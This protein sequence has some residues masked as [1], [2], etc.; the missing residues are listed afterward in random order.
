MSE[1]LLDDL[2]CRGNFVKPVSGACFGSPP[3]VYI[4]DHDTAP[5]EG[6]VVTQDHTNVVI[7]A[8][9]LKDGGRAGKGKGKEAADPGNKGKRASHAGGSNPAGKRPCLGA[10]ASG[11]RQPRSSPRRTYS[12]RELQAM[13]LK[14]LAALLGEYGEAPKA[15]KSDVIKQILDRQA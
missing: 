1:S 13:S 7:R 11:S 9:Q 10:G 5:P 4:C 14:D 12:S 6:Q 2:P 3:P 15:R 8:L